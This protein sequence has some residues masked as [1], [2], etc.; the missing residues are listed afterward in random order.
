MNAEHFIQIFNLF[1]REANTMKP[2]RFWAVWT[3]ATAAAVMYL[4]PPLLKA[5]NS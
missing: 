2:L 3:S 4:L 1:K 5:L